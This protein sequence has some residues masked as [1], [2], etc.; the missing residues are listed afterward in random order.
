MSKD[1]SP[2]TQRFIKLIS[3]LKGQLE[4]YCRRAL[5]QSDETEDVLQSV[6]TLSLRDFSRFVEGTNFRAWIFRYTVLEVANRNRAAARR[7]RIA[8]L[9][10]DVEQKQVDSMSI[11]LGGWE[12]PDAIIEALADHFDQAVWEALRELSDKQRAILLLRSIGEFSYREI[13]EILDVPIGTVMGLLSRARA[14]LRIRLQTYAREHGFI[15]RGHS[16]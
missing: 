13:G 14:S 15:D 6:V 11:E 10:D 3:S 4:G 2:E 7:R 9:G 5:L 12:H 1:C 16:A 8:P